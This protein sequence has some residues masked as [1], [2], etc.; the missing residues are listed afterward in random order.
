MSVVTGNPGWSNGRLSSVVPERIIAENAGIGRLLAAVIWLD[1]LSGPT[2]VSL[3][4]PPGSTRE[5]DNAG[6]ERLQRPDDLS[7]LSRGVLLEF[8][9]RMRDHGGALSRGAPRPDHR[10]RAAA[11]SLDRPPRQPQHRGADRR[12]SRLGRPRDDRRHD[13]P[14]AGH[15]EAHRPLPCPRQ[16][17]GGRRARTRRRART[18]IARRTSRCSAKPKASSTSSSRLGRLASAKACSRSRNSPSTSPRAR[19]R[20]SIS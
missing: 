5:G 6:A 2:G 11:A 12:R 16:A 9:G 19:S 10:G 1:R 20:A 13:G 7:A 4:P 3:G 17:G 15:A 8:R 14:A 18:S